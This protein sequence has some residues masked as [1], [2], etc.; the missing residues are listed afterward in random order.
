MGHE[1]GAEVRGM[2]AGR[3]REVPAFTGR[4]VAWGYCGSDGGMEWGSRHSPRS[5]PPSAQRDGPCVDS[6]DR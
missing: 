3:R 2:R 5:M 1:R 6:L 4:Q